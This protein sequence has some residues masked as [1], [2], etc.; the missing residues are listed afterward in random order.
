MQSPRLIAIVGGSGA[1]KTWLAGR[2]QTLL[3]PTASRLS[4]DD[5][6][7]DRELLPEEQRKS[8][9][10]DHP[11]AIDWR[12]FEDVLRAC[13]AGK[14]TRAPRYCFATHSRTLSP[15]PFLPKSIVLVEGLWLL[16]RP[17]V[18]RMFDLSIYLDCPVHLRLERRL[19]RDIVERGRCSVA[20]REQFW[21]TVSPMHD[22]FVAP[23]ISSADMVVKHAPRRSEIEEL[24]N[25][26]RQLRTDDAA[27]HIFASSTRSWAGH[28]N[29]TAVVAEHV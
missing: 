14:S 5:F 29:P 23:Q 8:L 6:Y 9:N 28:S 21:K 2:L 17:E 15:D 19:K 20:V 16:V 22:L 24:A 27:D 12:W 10:Y 1:G 13:R 18:R 4:L 25:A 7:H 11:S 26:I 3:Q